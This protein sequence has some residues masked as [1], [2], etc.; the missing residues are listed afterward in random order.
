MTARPNFFIVGAPK[1]GTT[2][3]AEYLKT[4]PDIGF[5]REKE[6]HYFNTDFPDFRWAKTETEYLA[7]FEGCAGKTA[8]G[9]A[10]V[11]Y[12]YSAEAAANIARFDPKAKI[13]IF[14][15]DPASFL[16]SYHNQLLMN[17]DEDV[18]D[19]DQA[20]TSWG[21]RANTPP[22]TCRDAKFL[23]YPAVA[24]FGEQI[25]RF[26][27]CF[28]DDQIMILRMEEWKADP[29]KAYQEVLAFLGLSD[30]GRTEFP[31]IHEAKHHS[32]DVVAKL[33]QRPP[34]WALNVA[35]GL[36][37]VLGLKRL[38]LSRVLRKVNTGKGYDQTAAKGISP[39]TMAEIDAAL[40]EDQA[41]L[42]HIMKERDDA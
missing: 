21:A 6:P 4:H 1:C 19:F 18:R 15:R 36:R 17:L 34:G 7:L 2:A 35:G 3:W 11:I 41:L 40:A 33:V 31:V 30:D 42:Q 14:L 28:P 38:G 9:E 32:S 39:Q 23:N 24:R 5:A 12:L 26:R 20:W 13:L 22:A 10:S 29:R 27:S 16:P 8:I 25:A 37:R